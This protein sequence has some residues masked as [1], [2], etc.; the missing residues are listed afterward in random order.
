MRMALLIA[1]ICFD[2]VGLSFFILVVPDEE[3][4]ELNEVFKL[5]FK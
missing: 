4:G 1:V 3:E 5:V 2:F